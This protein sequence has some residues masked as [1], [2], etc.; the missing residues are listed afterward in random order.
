MLTTGPQELLAVYDSC[1][2][3]ST[4]V[5]ALGIF[6][7]YACHFYFERPTRADFVKT[8]LTLFFG[9]LVL[10]GVVGE[11]VF[12]KKISLLS[13][14]IQQTSDQTIAALKFQLG[15]VNLQIAKSN[16]EAAAA[17]KTASEANE[18]VLKAEKQTAQAQAE[19][20][21]AFERAMNTAKEQ[22]KIRTM[23]MD[24]KIESSRPGIADEQQASGL[25]SA[26]GSVFLHA[27]LGFDGPK[28]GISFESYNLISDIE[29]GKDDRFH[30]IY[31]STFRL[32]SLEVV[33]KDVSWLSDA[34]QLWFNFPSFVNNV[35]H[36]RDLSHVTAILY[37][38]GQPF[39]VVDYQQG[40]YAPIAAISGLNLTSPLNGISNQFGSFNQTGKRR[41]GDEKISETHP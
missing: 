41:G 24:L 38:N 4:A 13:K 21:D 23:T 26:Y 20:A 5:V 15:A 3:I 11:F 37:V 8:A 18:R 36:D 39:K 10:G 31:L 1:T 6:G 32:T 9:A 40:H 22:S 12:G 14:E 33:G 2:A 35:T 27:S 29:K 28:Q 19:A 7:E 17:R 25:R 30:L 16:E 34:K